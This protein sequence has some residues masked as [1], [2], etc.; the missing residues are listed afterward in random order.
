[1]RYARRVS[2]HVE[3]SETSLGILVGQRVA[4]YDLRFFASLRMTSYKAFDQEA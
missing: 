4:R 1:V 2:C 3:R